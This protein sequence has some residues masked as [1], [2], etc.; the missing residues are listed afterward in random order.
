[1]PCIL[2]LC[3]YAISD[4]CS[5]LPL[6][7]QHTHTR[8]PCET[9]SHTIYTCIDVQLKTC[10][11]K[12]AIIQLQP[13]TRWFFYLLISSFLCRPSKNVEQI[14]NNAFK[15]VKDKANRSRRARAEHSPPELVHENRIMD[16]T[17][18]NVEKQNARPQHIR[19]YTIIFLN[20][21]NS[22]SHAIGSVCADRPASLPRL[23]E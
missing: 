23:R 16:F 22:H 12:S 21:P 6:L 3:E 5:L 2:C 17:E 9:D 20:S 11:R 13:Q 4:E 1:M 18:K 19:N 14:N 8:C 7:T 15:E 10:E